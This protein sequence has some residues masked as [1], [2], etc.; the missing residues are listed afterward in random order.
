MNI[1]RST[2]FKISVLMV[3]G[4]AATVQPVSAGVETE[5]RQEAE[6]YG[7]M[8]ELQ[9]EY[10][11]GCIESRGGASTSN[12]DEQVDLQPSASDDNDN[13]AEGEEN[14]N[15]NPAE[16]EENIAE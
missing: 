1:I 3:L 15:D 12:S 7:V 11:S 6:D 2:T 14:I 5:C 16:G 4:F 8:P 13:P 9:N 10:I